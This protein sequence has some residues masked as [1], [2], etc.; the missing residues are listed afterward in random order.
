MCTDLSFLCLQL[1]GW[2]LYQY[3]LG[4]ALCVLQTVCE[5]L[6]EEVAATLTQPI[7][8]PTFLAGLAQ[9]SQPDLRHRVTAGLLPE[10]M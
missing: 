8:V 1:V 6:D 4:K 10:N 2:C 3:L 7:M 9:Q 5:G